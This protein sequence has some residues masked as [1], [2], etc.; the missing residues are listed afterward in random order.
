M[1]DP[2]TDPRALNLLAAQPDAVDALGQRCTLLACQAHDTSS[3][4]RGAAGAAQWTGDAA[5]TFRR[6][7][8]KLPVS[9][10]RCTRPTA[11][12]AMPWIPT[13]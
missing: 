12:P 5:D 7:A 8:T 4:V 2:L 11:R 3:G 6:W 1:T 9:W 10:I 13:G